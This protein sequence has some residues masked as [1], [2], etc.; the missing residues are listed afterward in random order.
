MSLIIRRRN[1][2]I[3]PNAFSQRGFS[4]VGKYSRHHKIG[5]FAEILVDN[6]WVC[7]SVDGF[8]KDFFLS[9]PITLGST[10][11]LYKFCR[12]EVLFEEFLFSKFRWS[13]EHQGFAFLIDQDC[14]LIR[15]TFF[16]NRVV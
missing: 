16:I 15:S 3:K 5:N 12:V 14:S 2:T 1:I 7:Y 13:K 9:S 11:I 10:I 6:I 4:F 8:M